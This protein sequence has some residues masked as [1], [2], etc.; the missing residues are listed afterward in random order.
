VKGATHGHSVRAPFPSYD[1][2]YATSEHQL[3]I[4]E[5]PPY[6]GEDLK[7]LVDDGKVSNGRACSWVDGGGPTVMMLID[8]E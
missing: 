2:V 8:G 5:E 7:T 4:T 1:F 3:I 6:T